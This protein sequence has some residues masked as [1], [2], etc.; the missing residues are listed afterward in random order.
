MS[1][2]KHVPFKAR[3]LEVRQ[4]LYQSL[5]KQYDDRLPVIVERHTQSELPVIEKRKYLVPHNMTVTNFTNVIKQRLS[6]PPETSLFLCA[7]GAVLS[8]GEALMS[9]IYNRHRDQSDGFLYV[10][11]RGEDTMG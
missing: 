9:E 4:S 5:V 6:L 7:G 10:T 11:Y 2:S 3:S 8:P 1:K